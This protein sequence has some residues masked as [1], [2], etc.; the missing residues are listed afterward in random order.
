MHLVGVTAHPTGA[1]VTQAAWNLLIDLDE[2]VDRFRLLIR[3]RDA[4]FTR[5]FDAVFAAA[6]V[7]ILKIPPGA[8]KANAFAERWVRTVRQERRRRVDQALFAVVMEAYLHGVSTRKV[9]DL[10]KALG[11]D[12]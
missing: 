7:E 4:E 12:S 9:D 3:D 5:A 1:W 2:R 10:V 8:P 6:G 11:A